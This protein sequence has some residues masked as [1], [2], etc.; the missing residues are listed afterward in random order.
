MSAPLAA[1]REELWEGGGIFGGGIFELDREFK[2]KSTCE[3][4]NSQTH[5]D[6]RHDASDFAG[7]ARGEHREISQGEDMWARAGTTRNAE[8]PEAIYSR[9]AELRCTHLD[10]SKI[11]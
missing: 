6:Q 10:W 5:N 4:L 3:P 11:V 9:P 2:I 1:L 8:W 7:A